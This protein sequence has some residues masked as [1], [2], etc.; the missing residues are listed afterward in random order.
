MKPTPPTHHSGCGGNNS[1]SLNC[2]KRSSPT[3]LCVSV[4]VGHRRSCTHKPGRPPQK[5]ANRWLHART[6]TSMFG[7]CTHTHTHTHTNKHRT[8]GTH[9]QTH[10]HTHTR[11]HI[12]MC[13]HPHTNTHKSMRGHQHTHNYTHIHI[14]VLVRTTGEQGTTVIQSATDRPC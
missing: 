14:K 5:T 1:G 2:S 4:K 12:S 13:R 11:V 8:V 9:T 6:Y 7:Q 3:L 10:T